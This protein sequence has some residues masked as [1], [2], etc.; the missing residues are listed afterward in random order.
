MVLFGKIM[1]QH[2]THWLDNAQ[3]PI[4]IIGAMQPEIALLRTWLRDPREHTFGGTQIFCGWLDGQAVALMQS[5]IGKVNAS[6]GTTLLIQ[7]FGARAIINTGSAGGLAP[8][9]AVGDVVIADNAAHHDVDVTA[10]GYQR[11][12]MAQMPLYYPCDSALI[13]HATHASSAF[14]Q[15]KVH[16]GLVVSGDSFIASAKQRTQILTDFPKALAVEMEAAAIAQTCYQFN[17]PF[18]II[19]AISDTA[20]SDASHSFEEF[21]TLA[22]KHSA[23]MVRQIV[24]HID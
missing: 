19:R 11:G 7:H 10:F 1:P 12:Q 24:Q 15:A 23:E 8:Q 5:G 13:A 6:I 17:T 9:L 16:R 3:S 14:S 20:D 22:G 18:A 4:A 21:I 2:H